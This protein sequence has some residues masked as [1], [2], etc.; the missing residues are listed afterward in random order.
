[1]FVRYEIRPVGDLQQ[2]M[3][4]VPHNGRE[5][6]DVIKRDSQGRP[7]KDAQGR[8]IR[9]RI[10]AYEG[11]ARP[12]G[13]LAPAAVTN[14]LLI[15]SRRGSFRS[16]FTNGILAAQWLKNVLSEDGVIERDE[17]INKISDPMR[18]SQRGTERW[19]CASDAARASMHSC[20]NGMPRS[21]R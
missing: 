1:M 21:D 12:L 19:M 7:L 18:S 16:T 9:K 8:I 15:T 2:G 20:T 11:K 5:Y 14:D 17:L 6:A 4:S 10:R 3:E 13:Y